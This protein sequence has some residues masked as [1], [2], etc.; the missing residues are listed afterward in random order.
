MK[1]CKRELRKNPVAEAPVKTKNFFNFPPVFSLRIKTNK[2]I[3]SKL[4]RTEGIRNILEP[5]N[6]SLK[7]GTKNS[8]NKTRKTPTN[9]QNTI[10]VDCFIVPIII[11][12]YQKTA[13]LAIS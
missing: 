8:P 4:K 9:V 7:T 3:P 11:L 13:C 10:I 6:K 5:L 2:I 12:F 1:L